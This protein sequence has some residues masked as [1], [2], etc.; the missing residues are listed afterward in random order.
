VGGS[1]QSTEQTRY[2]EAFAERLASQTPVT[3]EMW[4]EGYTSWAARK[5]VGNSPE[6]RRSGRVDSVAAALILQSYLDHRENRP[7]EATP[8]QNLRESGL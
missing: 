1:G 3:V 6:V 2:S 4:D 8:Q 5:I 7:S